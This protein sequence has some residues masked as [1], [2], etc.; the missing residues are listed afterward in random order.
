MSSPKY[1]LGDDGFVVCQLIFSAPKKNKPRP[2]HTFRDNRG[3]NYDVITL[4]D[5]C[6]DCPTVKIPVSLLMKNLDDTDWRDTCYNKSLIEPDDPALADPEGIISV[7]KIFETP[8]LSPHH[9]YRIDGADI[10]YPLL[11]DK[12]NNIIDG[13]HRLCRALRNGWDTIPIKY[14]SKEILCKAQIDN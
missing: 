8:G 1:L 7:R 4:W 10:S 13:M 3:R 6:D 14:V 2:D 12:K 11:V 5:L 9:D